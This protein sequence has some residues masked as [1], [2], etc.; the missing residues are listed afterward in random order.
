VAAGAAALRAGGCTALVLSGAAA[1]GRYVEA[2][3]MA[4]L[5]REL[6]VP[7]AQIVVEDRARTTWENVGCAAPHLA[8]FDRILVVSEGLHAR[9]AK[10]YLCRQTPAGCERVTALRSELPLALFLWRL[11]AALYEL[12]AFVRDLAAHELGG[13]ADAPACAAAAAPA[14]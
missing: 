3:T 5:A 6:G 12:R 2:Q 14:P 1:H 13:G 10:R 11:G 8:G 7:E 4:A 9:R